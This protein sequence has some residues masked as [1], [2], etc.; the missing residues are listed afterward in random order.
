MIARVPREVGMARSRKLLIFNRSE[1]VL[2]PRLPVDAI[3]KRLE[4]KSLAE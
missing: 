3:T 1:N 2:D 4:K